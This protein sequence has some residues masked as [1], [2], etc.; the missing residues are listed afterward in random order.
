[1]QPDARP[2]GREQVP[3]NAPRQTTARTGRTRI[4]IVSGFVAFSE[5]LAAV[6]DSTDDLSFAGAVRSIRDA[7][8]LLRRSH[9][10][11]ILVDGAVPDGTAITAIPT[12]LELAP[13]A[14]VLVLADV[15]DARLLTEALE[16][17]ASGFIERKDSVDVVLRAIRAARDGEMVISREMLA[18]VVERQR[19]AAGQDAGMA[20]LLTPREIEVLTLMGR[21]LDPNA[22][23]VALD[24]RLSTCRGYE[25]SIMAKLDVHSQLDAVVTA[26]RR[27]L[28]PPLAE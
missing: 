6:L 28:I 20:G 18:S 13:L 1:M 27:G 2:G 8:P 22:I 4:A 16:A 5:L 14:T 19:Q 12:L 15:L 9:P 26:I 23:A 3:A 7:P 10:N 25:K 11:V 17:G 24:I 21:G